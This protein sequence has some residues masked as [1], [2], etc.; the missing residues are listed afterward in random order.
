M[1]EIYASPSIT[2]NSPIVTYNGTSSEQS[3]LNR[4]ADTTLN[5]GAWNNSAPLPDLNKALV[6][7][8]GVVAE[9][10]T[11]TLTVGN[12]TSLLKRGASGRLYIGAFVHPD[13]IADINLA[14][15]DNEVLS[16]SIILTNTP[17]VYPFDSLLMRGAAENPNHVQGLDIGAWQTP[18]PRVAGKMPDVPSEPSMFIP[19]MVTTPSALGVTPSVSATPGLAIAPQV[20][21]TQVV[22]TSNFLALFGSDFQQ[23]FLLGRG[24]ALYEMFIDDLTEI[25]SYKMQIIANSAS[26]DYSDD[27][28]KFDFYTRHILITTWNNPVDVILT[29]HGTE[30]W[31]V[32]VNGFG[33]LKKLAVRGYKIKNTNPGRVARYQMVAFG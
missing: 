21:Q 32:N 30:S 6:D 25:I 26:D 15:V 17:T 22:N 5:I 14:L 4:G 29:R 1:A 11:P 7:N 2:Y 23:N 27:F 16:E 33:F 19:A 18:F 28:I 12:R 13:A 8:L 31:Y 3:I 9:V 20:T 24:L 10:F